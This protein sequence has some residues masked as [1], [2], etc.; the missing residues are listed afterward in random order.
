MKVILLKDV[1]SVGQHGEVKNVADG[2]AI[3]FLFPQKLA[4]PATEEKIKQLDATQKAHEAEVA[5]HEAELDKK[6]TMVRGKKVVLQARA[7]EKGGLFKSVTKKDIAKAILAE[8]SVEIPESA[9]E[10]TEDHIKTV[11]E[12]KVV[13][14]SKNEKSDLSV[15]IVPAV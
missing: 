2:Y 12:H 13:L 5:K 11:G 4:E 1:R 10:L 7:T 8:H 14:Y 6:V 9:I 15:A 3:N